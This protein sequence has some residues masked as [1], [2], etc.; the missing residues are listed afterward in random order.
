LERFKV[1]AKCRHGQSV[2]DTWFPKS[3]MVSYVAAR[4][5]T[6]VKGLGNNGEI[7]VLAS[8]KN[9]KPDSVSVDVAR[10]APSQ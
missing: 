10:F 6:R 1:I 9:P 8:I 3:M 5:H 7:S 2:I 4:P